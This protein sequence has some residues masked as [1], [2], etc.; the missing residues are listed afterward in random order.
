MAVVP[1]LGE[2][3]SDSHSVFGPAYGFPRLFSAHSKRHPLRLHDGRYEC[4]FCG[5]I[6]D[7]PL[8]DEPEVTIRA[9]GG[10][11]NFRS[12]TLNG[13]EIHRCEIGSRAHAPDSRLMAPA[14]VPGI[15]VAGV[16]HEAGFPRSVILTRLQ[17]PVIMRAMSEPRAFSEAEAIAAYEAV[18]LA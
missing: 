3:R 16:L 8:V 17:D 13:K 4:G 7:I 12:L 18:A 1:L 2:R 5:E 6:L 14:P 15:L 11:P 9:A 10:L